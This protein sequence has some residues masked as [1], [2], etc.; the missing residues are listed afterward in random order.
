VNTHV[1]AT[2][3]RLRGMGYKPVTPYLN[4]DGR[5]VTCMPARSR[6]GMLILLLEPNGSYRRPDDRPRRYTTR[7]DH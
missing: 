4:T 6:P 1:D 5:L 3:E 2:I 7:K